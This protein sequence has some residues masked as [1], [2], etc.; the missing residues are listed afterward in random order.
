VCGWLHKNKYRGWQNWIQTESTLFKFAIGSI[1]VGE[2]LLYLDWIRLF[3]FRKDYKGHKYFIF[4]ISSHT[5]N[6]G[7]TVELCVEL[8]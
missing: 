4:A 6:S 1:A 7:R 8:S 3:E 2:G 5:L